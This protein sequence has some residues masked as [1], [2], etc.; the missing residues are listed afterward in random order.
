MKRRWDEI[1]AGLEF[2]GLLVVC[3]AFPGI[4]EV[5]LFGTM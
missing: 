1:V 2:F 4:V 3:L 5:L